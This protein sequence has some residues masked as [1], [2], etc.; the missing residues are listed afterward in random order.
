MKETYKIFQLKEGAEHSLV[1]LV[2]DKTLI[3]GELDFLKRYLPRNNFPLNFIKSCFRIK[4][5]L[6]FCP[7]Q[8]ELTIRKKPLYVKI[9]FITYEQII[10]IKKQLRAKISETYPHL[11]LKLIFSNGYTFG[12]FFRQES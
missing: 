9:P 3:F 5:N 12:S 11:H 10:Y 2:A 4:L 1:S 8:T 7:D 6:L